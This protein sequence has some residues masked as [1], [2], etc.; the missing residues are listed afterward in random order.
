MRSRATMTASGRMPC[1]LSAGCGRVCGQS[2]H[3]FLRPD[4]CVFDPGVKVFKV[5]ARHEAGCGGAHNVP[6]IVRRK[7]ESDDDQDDLVMISQECC[8]PEH[9]LD[10]RR[11]WWAEADSVR[12]SVPRLLARIV[13]NVLAQMLGVR[14][15]HAALCCCQ[16]K[17]ATS[18]CVCEKGTKVLVHASVSRLCVSFLFHLRTNQDST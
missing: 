4:L 9:R 14:S 16:D 6:K 10:R 2:A 8:L 3:L 11:R 17:I 12:E 5:V 7:Q 18:L 1:G 15:E 13:D